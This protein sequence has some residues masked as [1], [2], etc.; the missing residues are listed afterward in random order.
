MEVSQ[1]LAS[2][3][4]YYKAMNIGGPPIQKKN[5]PISLKKKITIARDHH[6]KKK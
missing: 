6:R 5:K 4:Y 2:R 3:T 1:T